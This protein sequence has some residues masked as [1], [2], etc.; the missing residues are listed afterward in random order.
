M[1]IV[2][3]TYE[4]KVIVSKQILTNAMD[5]LEKVK[6][7]KDLLLIQDIDGVCIPLVKDPLMR[8]ID[9]SYVRAAVK[10]G[11]EFSVLT[12]GEHEGRRG[13]NRL[14]ERSLDKNFA[15]VAKEGFFLPGLAAGG[16]QYQDNFGNLSHPGVSTSEKNFLASIPQQMQVSLEKKLS[17]L[18]PALSK[19]DVRKQSHLSILDTE[20]SPTINLN[21]LFEL[22]P[23]NVSQKRELQSMINDVMQEIIAIA[24]ENGYNNSFH[25]HIAPNLGLNGELEIIKYADSG[26]VGTTDIQLMLSGANKEAGVLVLIN[27]Y[28]MKKDGKAPLGENFNSRV[29]P[30]S[31]KEQVELCI[32]NIPQ[33]KMPLI[34]GVGD[35][36]TST[37]S[38]ENNK[39][40]RGGSDRGFLTLIQ[41]L[42]KAYDKD[43]QIFIVDS[44]GGEV[45]RPSL[46]NK[47]LTGIS[48]P[49]DPL[50][51]NILFKD[52]PEEY[53]SWFKELVKIRSNDK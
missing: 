30:K 34:I 45:E 3:L 15:E 37:K 8:K 47:N 25:L 49:Y 18:M 7:I 40:L 17:I 11:D 23:N 6:S 36:V 4:S 12:N 31:I 22:I 51:F 52:G 27:R 9:A 24:K 39:W 2:C 38:T 20:L 14:V 13:V 42:G 35:T 46:L 21:R 32:K 33:S 16:V 44:S 5:I 48:D 29:A 43:N 28:I 19:E 26:D 50:K 53:I 10:L 1:G 41:E